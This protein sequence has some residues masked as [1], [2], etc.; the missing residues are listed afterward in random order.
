MIEVGGILNDTYEIIQEIG[1]GGTGIVYLAYHKRLEKQV[2]LKKIKDDFVGRI[3]ERGEADLL[4]GLRHEYLPQVYDFIQLGRQI[5][6]VMDY[7]QG[8]PLSYYIEEGRQFS[9]RQLLIWLRQLC[10]VLDYLHR[11]KPPIVHS[12]VKPSNIMVTPAGDICLIDFNISL[13]GGQGISGFSERYASPE[14]LFISAAM[15]GR[16]FP[17][18]PNLAGEVR[19]LDGRSDIYSLGVTFYHVITGIQPAPYQP[20]GPKLRPLES[21]KLPYGQ[22]FL[23]IISKAMEPMREKRYQS[24]AE[25]EGDILGMKRRDK[26]YRRAARGQRFLAAAGCLLMAGGAALGVWGFQA[27]LS[28]QFTEQYEEVVR[29]ARTDDYEEITS[30]GIG[31]LNNDKYKGV[32]KREEEKKADL[33]YM[34]ANSYFEQDD[35]GNALGFYEEAVKYNKKNPEYF[36]DYAIALARLEETEEAERVLE[37]AVE[38]GLER[39]HICLVQAEISA[40]RRDYG[41]AVENFQ[42]AVRLTENDYLRTRAYLLCSRVYRSMEDIEG[43]LEMLRKAGEQPDPGQEKAVTRARGAACMRAYNREKDSQ[44]K[45]GLLEEALNCYYSLVNGSQ[46]VF[47]DR[48]NLAVLYEIAGNY[49]EAELQLLTMKE[50]YPDDYR[51]YMRLALFYCSVEGRK[52]EK[53]RNY[54]LAEEN[55][56][57]AEQYY[58]KA[59]NSGVSDENMQDLQEIMNQLYEKGWLKAK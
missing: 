47:Q 14:Q 7:V 53:Q 57:L 35:Y 11:Q 40:G 21:F 8:Y 17:R 13:E 49:Q 16:P 26:E 50:L 18:D 41:T 48:M 6:T 52:E 51:V 12:D 3:N 36:R 45:L 44:E 15:S 37:E 38:L 54:G 42:E 29:I 43:E 22:D 39:D 46:P 31:L 59:L 9:Q 10:Q 5:F 24:A 34:V 55:Y 30:R 56:S 58:Q 4:K 25:L 2:I 33:L 20:L 19:G 28:E 32:M 1:E 23:K 27:K